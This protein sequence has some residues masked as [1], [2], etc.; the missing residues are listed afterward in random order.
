M[1]ASLVF[2]LL[3]ALLVQLI[4]MLAW[5]AFSIK[6]IATVS[7]VVSLVFAIPAAI[8][9]V[10]YFMFKKRIN[11]WAPPVKIAAV[12]SL[13]GPLFFL[14]GVGIYH[15]PSAGWCDLARWAPSLMRVSYKDK[16]EKLDSSWFNWMYLPH[17]TYDARA[18]E[19]KD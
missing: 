17:L 1:L 10:L 14:V 11:A 13:V 9:I 4:L 18:Q 3:A 8:A 6:N 16:C 2:T 19:N 5:I 12:V 15:A 7:F